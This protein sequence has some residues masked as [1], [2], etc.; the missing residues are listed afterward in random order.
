MKKSTLILGVVSSFLLLIG[1]GMKSQHWPGAGVALTL[2]AVL[3]VL[4]YAILLL[5]DKNKI[6]QND[7]QKFVNLMTLATMVIIMTAFLFKVQHWP[8]A[9]IGI[10]AGHIILLVMIPVL[11]IQ[12]SRETDPVKKLN[13]NN[14]AVIFVLLTAFSFF[15]WLVIGRS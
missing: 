14:I 10:W 5:I 13:F 11:F 12:A 7:F 9:R 8:G 4:G 1:V 3:F 6:A 2:G 15:I